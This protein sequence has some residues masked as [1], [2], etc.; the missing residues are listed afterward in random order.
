[1]VAPINIAKWTDS[2]VIDAVIGGLMV[3]YGMVYGYSLTDDR[4]QEQFAVSW[5]RFLGGVC[6][7]LLRL[8]DRWAFPFQTVMMPN[9]GGGGDRGGSQGFLDV[10]LG[11]YP[12]KLFKD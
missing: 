4:K 5:T 1:M 2:E 12:K 9:T 8:Y 6:L 11:S 3:C 10:S 7:C